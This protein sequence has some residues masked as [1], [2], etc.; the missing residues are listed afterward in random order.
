MAKARSRAGNGGLW[1]V[2][3]LLVLVALA[4][5]LG[6]KV[7]TVR[8]VTITGVKTVS[9]EDVLS[10]A[11]VQPDSNIFVV[12]KQKIKQGVESSPYL[13]FEKLVRRLPNT[14]EIVVRERVAIAAVEYQG[15][16]M[17]IDHEGILLKAGQDEAGLASI[18]GMKVVA[19]TV[20]K[21]LQAADEYQLKVATAVLEALENA[22]M[23]NSISQI[24]VT[25]T[26]N[27]E[28]ISRQSYRVRLGTAED[29]VMK[30]GRMNEI[31]PMLVSESRYGGLLDVSLESPSYSPQDSFTP[32][33]PAFSGEDGTPQDDPEQGEPQD[34]PTDT[35][36]DEPQGEPEDDSGNEP[37]QTQSPQ[38]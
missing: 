31:I 7:F 20:G 2:M 15:A 14:L 3:L 38:D 25:D 5:F 32:S 21:P 30:L 36:E 17:Q 27:V 11:D 19:F 4:I 22:G 29:L 23:Q 28:L 9:A 1:A 10:L 34:Q 8:R 12:D 33:V 13:V 6:T 35:P 26:E 18:I 16:F 37:G 24:D